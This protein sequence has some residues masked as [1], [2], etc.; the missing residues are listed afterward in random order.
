MTTDKSANY[1]KTKAVWSEMLAITVSKCKYEI[2]CNTMEI[3][4][5]MTAIC[6]IQTYR[7]SY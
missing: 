5:L 1:I 3:K 6:Q 7:L 4:H 2:N